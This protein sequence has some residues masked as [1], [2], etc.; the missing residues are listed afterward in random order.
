[1]QIEQYREAAR[2][3]AIASLAKVYDRAEKVWPQYEGAS[4]D[5][6]E[7]MRLILEGSKTALMILRDERGDLVPKEAHGVQAREWVR[8]ALHRARSLEKVGEIPGGTFFLG[9]LTDALEEVAR[10]V[11]LDE[12]VFDEKHPG[13]RQPEASS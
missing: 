10:L 6:R 13:V 2:A 4:Y 1:M 9:P 7:R 3:S 5:E 8:T 11:V 12:I